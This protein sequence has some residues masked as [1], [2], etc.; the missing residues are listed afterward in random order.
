CN[1]NAHHEQCDKYC[2]TSH[3]NSSLMNTRFQISTAATR[4]NCPSA[5]ET[6]VRRQSM[7]HVLLE[8]AHW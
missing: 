2:Y 5:G 3:E 7:K 4:W 8:Q 6:S 1:P